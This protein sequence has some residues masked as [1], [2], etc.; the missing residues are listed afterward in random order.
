VIVVGA[1][2]GSYVADLL[3]GLVIMAVGVGG[4]FV[5]VATA[6]NAGVPED[7]SGLAAGLLNTAPQL[8]AA[9]G[10][11]I[12]SALA[13]ART[14]DLLAIHADRL[15]ALTSGFRRALLACSLCVLASALIA[16]RAPSTRGQALQTAVDAVPDAA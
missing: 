1:L 8:G 16:L 10:L 13:T 15:D 11:A 3:P 7:K 14:N 2:H 4:V 5:G 12:F 9:L 6:A